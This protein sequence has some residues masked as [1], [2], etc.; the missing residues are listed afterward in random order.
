V[1]AVRFNQD[2]R[3]LVTASTD[4]TAILW[5]VADRTDPR[6]LAP[7][8]SDD[9]GIYSAAWGPDGHTLALAEEG[10]KTTLWDV[11]DRTHPHRII[12]MQG[13]ASSVYTVGFSPTGQVLGTGGYDRTAILWDITDQPH[14]QELATLAG[15]P[16]AV[17]AVRFSPTRD[18]VAISAGTN[19]T[20]WDI[21]Q[22][23]AIVTRPEQ[24]V[25]AIVGRGL[26]PTEWTTYAPDIP[27][28][29]T[30]AN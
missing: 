21:T 19:V 15:Q 20:L 18:I 12:P 27:Y 1:R 14:P 9:F 4:A 23:T 8:L 26:N 30:C 13:Q 5:D 17:A 11:S 24:V 7:P 22:I 28:Q 29:Q 10:R 16:D 2:G 6:P 3:T 25:C